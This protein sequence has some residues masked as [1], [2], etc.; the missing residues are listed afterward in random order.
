MQQQRCSPPQPPGTATVLWA[1]VLLRAMHGSCSQPGA[2]SPALRNQWPSQGE[3]ARTPSQPARQGRLG[4]AY[5]SLRPEGVQGAKGEQR[6][7]QL[8]E[9]GPSRT[10][11]QDTLERMN[12]SLRPVSSGQ[13]WG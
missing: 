6:P 2:V 4:T 5:P 13:D 11:L 1:L 12:I 8:W 7:L 3:G 10:L 9:P